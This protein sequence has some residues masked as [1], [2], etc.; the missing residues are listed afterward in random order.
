MGSWGTRPV[1]CLENYGRGLLDRRG[2]SSRLPRWRTNGWVEYAALRKAAASMDQPSCDMVFSQLHLSLATSSE[3]VF[4]DK[5]RLRTGTVARSRLHSS[6]FAAHGIAH[7]RRPSRRS[8]PDKLFLA[9]SPAVDRRARGHRRTRLVHRH[10]PL[11]RPSLEHPHP[12]PRRLLLR[13]REH[14]RRHESHRRRPLLAALLENRPRTRR[15]L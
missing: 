4:H 10:R 11:D 7:C 13:R 12:I 15:P 3:V 9:G 1:P 5:K 8:H 14:L 6:P 2:K